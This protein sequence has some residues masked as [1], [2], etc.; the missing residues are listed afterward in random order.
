LTNNEFNIIKTHPRIEYDILGK[1]EFPWP[2]AEMVYQHHERLDGSGYPR[3]LEGDEIIVQARILAVADVVEAMTSRRPYR[4]ALGMETALEEISTGRDTKYDP[5]A[6]DVCVKLFKEEG[7][8][9]S[10]TP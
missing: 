5:D 9:F 4:T 10:G 8:G 6:V 7:F 2:I 3:G 1:I